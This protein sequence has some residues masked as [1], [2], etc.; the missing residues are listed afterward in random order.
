MGQRWNDRSPYEKVLPS[1]WWIYF[2]RLPSR[3]TDLELQ[4][5]LA[6][7]GLP[8]PL[9]QISIREYGDGSAAKIVLQKDDVIPI[10]N[11]MIDGKKLRERDVTAMGWS[12]GSAAHLAPTSKYSMNP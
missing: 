11:W 9:E 4:T 5:F 8:L 10:L 3:L 12:A 6:E 2:N 1:G 7:I